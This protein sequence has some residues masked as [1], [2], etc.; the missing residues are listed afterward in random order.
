[1]KNNNKIFSNK[2]LGILGGGQLGKMIAFEASRLGIKTCVYD[3][4][5]DAPALQNANIV[6]IEEYGNKKKLREFAKTCDAITYEFENIPLK[7]IELINQYCRVFPGINALKYSQERFLEKNFLSKIDIKVAR[8][9]KVDDLKTLKVKLKLLGGK[10]ILKTRKFGYDGKG[11]Y[12][13]KNYQLP[14]IGDKLKKDF[15][16]IEELIKFKKEISVIAFRSKKGKTDCY[17]PSENIHKNGILREALFP[18]RISNKCKKNAKDIAMKIAK[19]LKIVGIIAVEMFVCDN[20]EIIVNE[21]APRPHNSGH[22]TIDSCNV[23]QFEMLVRMMYEYPVTK[24]SY[25]HKCRM[26]N[27]LGLNY[28]MLLKSMEKKNHKVHVYGKNK[29]S[30]LRK[31]GHINILSKLNA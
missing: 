5:S 24:I 21:I 15:Y 31:L 17:E 11:Q 16:I 20:E 13:I 22:W 23:S 27:I 6:F 4:N 7:S 26:I 25:Y 30:P 28:H 29:I 19:K 9:F 12:I 18:A 8:F 2:I 10:A 3:P 14:E 1:M